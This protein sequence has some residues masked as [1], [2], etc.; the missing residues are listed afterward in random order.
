[1]YTGIALIVS[2]ILNIFLIKGGKK[3]KSEHKPWIHFFELKFVLA[4]M[5]TPAINPILWTFTNTVEE[6]EKMRGKIHFYICIF[7]YLYSSLIKYFREEMCN[8][9]DTDTVLEKVQELSKKYEKGDLKNM[10]KAYYDHEQ[11]DKEYD[12]LN[13]DA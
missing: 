5:L 11:G 12:D 6:T 7:M 10:H 2:G 4:L 9:F 13:K 3:L 8:N 1:M